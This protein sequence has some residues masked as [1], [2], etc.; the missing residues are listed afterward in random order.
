MVYHNI[1]TTLRIVYDHFNLKGKPIKAINELTKMYPEDL[2]EVVDAIRNT[3]HNNGYYRPQ[4]RN[5][6]ENF[7]YIVPEFKLEF[8]KDQPISPSTASTIY[9]LEK[10]I[11]C[12][13]EL[14]KDNMIQKIPIIEDRG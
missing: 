9:I 10:Y 13:I 5:Q 14:L 11:D 4:T 8:K 6:R 7:A 1:E 12:T 2:I 3:I